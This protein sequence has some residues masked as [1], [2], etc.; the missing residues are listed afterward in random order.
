MQIGYWKIRG[1]GAPIRLLLQYAAAEYEDVIYE[2]GDAPEFDD[3]CWTEK[4]F[5]MGMPFPNLPYLVDSDFKLTQSL[6]ILRYLGNKLGLAGSSQKE[7]AVIDMVADQLNDWKGPLY[8]EFLFLSLVFV[9]M[10]YWSWF[11]K[12]RF[13]SDSCLKLRLKAII[14]IV[15]RDLNLMRSEDFSFYFN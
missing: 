14:S 6:A 12:T 2:C 3:K 10:T 8:C 9:N 7:S 1:L 15:F 4:K 5:T 11:P 13:F